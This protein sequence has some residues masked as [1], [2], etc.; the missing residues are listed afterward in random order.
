MGAT[1]EIDG[2]AWAEKQV[3]ISLAGKAAERL[4][5]RG[6]EPGWQRWLS[7][8]Q[9][10]ALHEAGHAVIAI[11][12][13]RFVYQLSI[14]ADKSVTIQKTS[15]LAGFAQHGTEPLLPGEEP[16]PVRKHMKTDFFQAAILCRLLAPD[17]GWKSTLKEVRRLREKTEGLL[18]AN[19][20]IV[21]IL[22]AQ[23]TRR[24]HLDQAQ[25]E[26]VLKRHTI[27]AAFAA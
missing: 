19:M 8:E 17:P 26:K 16:P 24:K 4:A 27:T 3:I 7:R 2:R 22:A 18:A 21:E 9:R 25:I 15:Y 10:I 12:A 23:L 11:A 20:P 5:R 13:E 6:S 14:V 1:P